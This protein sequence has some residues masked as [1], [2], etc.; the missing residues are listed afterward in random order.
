MESIVSS[1]MVGPM[2]QTSSEV[3]GIG[4][5]KELETGIAILDEQH[6]R[7]IKLLNDYLAQ[8]T[9]NTMATEV[10]IIRLTESL[11][12][13]RQFAKEHFLTED[14]IMKDAEYP[15]LEEHQEEHSF[16]LSHVE[17]LCKNLETNGFTPKLSREVNY[18]IVKWFIEHILVLDMQLVDY[19][20]IKH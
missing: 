11:S 16:F 20:K 12:F 19:L 8:A 18:Y 5:T 6:R 7:Y 4:W 10:K 2:G 15:D 13:L 3:D 9:D 1:F 17:Q 14:T